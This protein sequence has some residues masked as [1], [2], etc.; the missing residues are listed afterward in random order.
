MNSLI[1]S[2]LDDPYFKAV[3]LYHLFRHLLFKVKYQAKDPDDRK[4]YY[5]DRLLEYIEID[6]IGSLYTSKIASQSEIISFVK[7]MITNDY[8]KLSSGNIDNIIWVNVRDSLFSYTSSGSSHHY[9]YFHL[10]HSLIHYSKMVSIYEN[11]KDIQPYK[12][13][14][15]RVTPWTL[16]SDGVSDQN[17]IDETL[18]KLKPVAERMTEIIKSVED[19]IYLDDKFREYNSY[20][21]PL[22]CQEMIELNKDNDVLFTDMYDIAIKILWV[23]LIKDILGISLF[24]KMD[25]SSINS[26]TLSQD[27]ALEIMNTIFPPSKSKKKYGPVHLRRQFTSVNNVDNIDK[28]DLENKYANFVLK[29][30]RL[31]VLMHIE[32]WLKVI[33]K[34]LFRPSGDLPKTNLCMVQ[35]VINALM[36]LISTKDENSFVKYKMYPLDSLV[37]IGGRSTDNEFLHNYFETKDKEIKESL[38]NEEKAIRQTT[39]VPG[40]YLPS[41]S[42]TIPPVDMYKAYAG[43]L[44]IKHICR[45]FESSVQIMYIQRL[46][47]IVL[48]NT[49]SVDMKE[50]FK[51]NIITND[52]LDEP[53]K[54]GELPLYLDKGELGAILI[55]IVLRNEKDKRVWHFLAPDT[56]NVIGFNLY[57]VSKPEHGSTK[58][59]SLYLS[60]LKV[61]QPLKSRANAY[62]RMKSQMEPGDDTEFE[63][64]SEKIG[65]FLFYPRSTGTIVRETFSGEESQD[66]VFIRFIK[67]MWILELM[68]YGIFTPGRDFEGFVKDMI[69]VD[70]KKLLEYY[71]PKLDI[72]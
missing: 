30:A 28:M 6:L 61:Y 34:K 63:D 32:K 54:D 66:K 10:K 17:V 18:E 37:A 39:K 41:P 64:L 65:S 22:T 43:Y 48:N 4:Y 33:E 23:T 36:G 58:M 38:S 20:E 8:R 24:D 56:K 2:Q 71:L 31:E 3:H 62:Q 47:N 19:N 21:L 11:E 35:I 68:I 49:K 40:H 27:Q 45:K 59:R 5:R 26:R 7:R 14:V 60:T 67:L 12:V 50:L 13:F 44:W 9:D 42:S 57:Y 52:Q 51:L 53:I 16:I 29:A 46:H 1:G 69:H 70:H 55:E 15:G 25:I 72:K